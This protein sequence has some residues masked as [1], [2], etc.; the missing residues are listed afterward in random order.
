MVIII[1]HI[2]SLMLRF[3]QH[4]A[5]PLTKKDANDDVVKCKLDSS[6]V[7]SSSSSHYRSS[8]YRSAHNL[9]LRRMI[10]LSLSIVHVLYLFVKCNIYGTSEVRGCTTQHIDVYIIFQHYIILKSSRSNYIMLHSPV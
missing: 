10:K 3:L 5:S 1:K 4:L 2:I 6:Q 9:Q 7:T 8:S